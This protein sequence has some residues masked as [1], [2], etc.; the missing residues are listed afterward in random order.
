MNDLNPRACCHISDK[1][2]R[3]ENR[4]L[5]APVFSTF[6]FCYAGGICSSLV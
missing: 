2:G 4:S 6:H 5:Q 3:N 1:I